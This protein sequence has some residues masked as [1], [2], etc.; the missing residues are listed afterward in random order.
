VAEAALAGFLID[1][2]TTNVVA[3][4]NDIDGSLLAAHQL[5]E[6][7]VNEAFFNERCKSCGVFM[8]CSFLW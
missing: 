6:H 7:L 5:A 8:E 3:T 4:A 2:G 1:F